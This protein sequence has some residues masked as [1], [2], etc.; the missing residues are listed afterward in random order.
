MSKKKKTLSKLKLVNVWY[1]NLI[2]LSASTIHIN[3]HSC[4]Y[5]SLNQL[6]YFSAAVLCRKIY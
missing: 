4:K 6:A 3:L 1:V 5:G 2:Y